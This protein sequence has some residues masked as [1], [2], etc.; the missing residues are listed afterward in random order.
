MPKNK[1]SSAHKK[2]CEAYKA[3]GQREK[4]KK[5]RLRKHIAKFPNDLVAAGHKLL[6]K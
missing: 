2:L 5:I 3:R 1:C 6:F 4:N